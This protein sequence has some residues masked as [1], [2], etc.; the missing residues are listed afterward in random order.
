[1]ALRSVLGE[2]DAKGDEM[3]RPAEP[4]FL[5]QWREWDRAGPPRC[6]HTCENYG[7][8]GQCVEFFMKPPAEFAATVGECPKWKQDIA[9]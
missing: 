2:V 4:K 6:C 9:F 3:T 8:D 7:N 1:M 5:V